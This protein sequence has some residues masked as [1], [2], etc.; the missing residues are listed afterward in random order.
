[1]SRQRLA[2]EVVRRHNRGDSNRSI[3]RSLQIDPKTVARILRDNASRRTDAAAAPAS[4]APRA[5]KLDRFAP[6]IG[7]LL[8][9][10]PDIHATRVLEEL[11]AQGFDGGYTIVREYLKKVRRSRSTP[12][13]EATRRETAPGRKGQVDW[14]HLELGDGTKVYALLVSLSFSRHQYIEISAN[15]EQPT[16][17]RILRRAFEAQGGVASEYIF[18]SMP[19]IVDRW[20]GGNPVLNL[21]AVDFAAH[22]H[23]AYDIAPRRCPK[24]KAGVERNVRAMRS[25]YLNGR[26]LRDLDSANAGLWHWL[27]YTRNPSKHP[28]RSESRNQL[29]AA[30][31]LKALPRRPYDTREMAWRLVDAY[32]YCRFD[33]NFYQAPSGLVGT[34]LCV[35]A[36]EAQVELYDRLANALAVHPRAP[37]GAGMHVPPPRTQAHSRRRIQELVDRFAAWGE[38]AHAWAQE[39]RKRKRCSGAELERVIVL[40]ERWRLEDVLE[41]LAHATRYGAYDARQLQRILEARAEPR[42]PTDLLSE[43]AR[44]QI[45]TTMADK[46]VKQRDIADYG[47]LLA[48]PKPTRQA[49]E[50]NDDGSE[51]S[52]GFGTVGEDS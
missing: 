1:M 11:Q 28:R 39:L 43:R 41:A 13:P 27:K 17:F 34:W 36:G 42:T 35:R 14:A 2:Y 40:Q 32:G 47:R 9:R 10:Y 29:L 21:A 4:R 3:A 38:V 46:P 6:T 18:D 16:L 44:S 50:D 23:F 45:R 25:G 5:S 19:G 7:E 20:E 24:Y 48:G 49:P 26:T 12:P 31:G 15:M 33:G 22:Y 30:E 37:R 52:R 8:A 51:D